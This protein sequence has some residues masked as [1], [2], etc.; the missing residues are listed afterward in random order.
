MSLA[1]RVHRWL[2]QPVVALTDDEFEE[3]AVT[4]YA[5][6][7]GLVTHSV[8]IPL[9]WLVGALYMSAVN[10]LSVAFYGAAIALCRRGLI[11]ASLILGI[12]ELI[13]HSW[14]ATLTFGWKASFHL[15]SVL[16]LELAVLSAYSWI[17]VRRRLVHAGLVMA[18]YL[19]LGYVSSATPG[20]IPISPSTTTAFV[21]INQTIFCLATAGMLAYHTWTVVQNRNARTS[22]Q[23]EV[24]ERTRMLE[25]KNEALLA[26]EEVRELALDVALDARAEAE[27]ASQA[28]SMF[29]ANMS[30]EL[31]TPL[32]AIIGYSE[33]IAEEAEDVGND[34]L[35]D[36]VG[37]ICKAGRHLLSLINDILD[38]SKIEA[39]RMEVEWV[40]FNVADCIHDVIDT[41]E[42]LAQDNHNTLK[43]NV[44]DHLPSL[45][46]DPT[47]L[48][49]IL[50]NLLSNAC[51]FTSDGTVTLNVNSDGDHVRFSVI[52]TGI[53]MSQEQ[54]SRVFVAF[55]QADG[56]TTRRFGG[57]GLGLAITQR[58]SE[59]LGG[60]LSVTS[61]LN[62]GS[63]FEV[64]LPR[65]PD[66]TLISTD[67]SSARLRRSTL[68]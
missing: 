7:A 51:K 11:R 28:K 39:G 4:N 57:T 13:G 67:G 24:L 52:D 42:P 31:R 40:E 18:L 25:E 37:R 29:L 17:S 10:I 1:I 55:T 41:V 54:L 14:L 6:T 3:Y 66:E 49:Q 16:A 63:C 20:W 64:S 50:Y 58:F 45:R 44:A 47:K 56:S 15:H 32:N 27:A 59:L 38:L 8:F 43:I 21:I 33:M 30:H 9:F 22:A 23:Q 68:G 65:H 60:S 2:A 26:S 19:S 48:R 5:L 12:V 46:S 35:V 36:E 61:Q 62:E 53:G 34:E